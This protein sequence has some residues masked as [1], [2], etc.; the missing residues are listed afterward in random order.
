MGPSII[1]Q[2]M[3]SVSSAAAQH[4]SETELLQIPR[5]SF[6]YLFANSGDLGF[7]KLQA[8]RM[9]DV[10]KGRIIKFDR[11][12]QD[13]PPFLREKCKELASAMS[14]FSKTFAGSEW[15]PDIE[16]EIWKNLSIP[17]EPRRIEYTATGAVDQLKKI[18]ELSDAVNGW[19][20]W[21]DKS[22]DAPYFVRRGRWLEEYAE[23]SSK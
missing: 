15:A 10:L 18:K 20:S 6:D 5:E 4:R 13:A 2:E 9:M 17:E 16:V 3:T 8:D 11:G 23:R 1:V 21:K 14:D 12:L 7:L 22:Y 19:F